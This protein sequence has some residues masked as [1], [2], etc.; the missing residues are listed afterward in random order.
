M[1]LRG[2]KVMTYFKVVQRE[3]FVVYVFKHLD[4]VIQFIFFSR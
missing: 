1:V 2:I 4:H 3:Y